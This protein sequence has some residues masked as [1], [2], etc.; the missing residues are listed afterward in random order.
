MLR[1]DEEAY[2]PVS[3]PGTS[4]IL[5]VTFHRRRIF[6]QKRMFQKDVGAQE[7]SFVR[8]WFQT[9]PSF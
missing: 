9:P 5:L 2:P 1:I 8:R 3:V 4:E 7:S 6:I